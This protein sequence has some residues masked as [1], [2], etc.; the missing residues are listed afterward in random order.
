MAQLKM[1]FN[2]E[3]TALPEINLADGFEI[4]TVSDSELAEYNA[5]RASVNFSSPAA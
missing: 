3:K 2:A 4:R 1:I 5:L